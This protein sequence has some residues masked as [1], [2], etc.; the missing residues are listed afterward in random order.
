MSTQPTVR[1][2]RVTEYEEALRLLFEDFPADERERRA[3]NALGFL[4]S[5]ELDPDGLLV[6][7]TD[8]VLAGVLVCLPVP[9][10]SALFWP[11]R[12]IADPDRAGREDRLVRHA[13]AWVRTRGA[14]LA[15][16]LLTADE[17]PLSGPLVRNGFRHVTRLWY[18]ANDLDVPVE[19]LSTPS[20]L[21]YRPYDPERPAAF[22]ETLL[23][24]YDGT[25]D[26]PEISG[27]R[28]IEDVI[29]GHRA[30]GR[31]DPARWW[32]TLDAGQPVGVLL[33]TL[34]PES[35]DWDISYLGV[36]PE[37]RRRGLGRESVLKA[38]FEAK[39]AG[40]GRVTLSVDG[41][42]K[43][44]LQLYAN[45]GF[46]PYDRRDVFLALRW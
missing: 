35:G 27:V 20:R 16:A 8:G 12:S 33:V 1:P 42:N 7:T 9:G 25:L 29:A 2:A 31:Y 40:I 36:V 45:L 43:P 3:V 18:L 11:P 28:T 17:I 44:A 14:K 15:Q 19:A 10:A 5:G 26:C 34:M 41:R 37:A 32:L 38:L 23:R 4:R 22:H 39:A 6:E 24:T 46:V 30:Q 13:L 21:E